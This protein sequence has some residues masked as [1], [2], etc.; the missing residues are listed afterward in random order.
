MDTVRKNDQFSTVL[1][2]NSNT[3]GLRQLQTPSVLRKQKKKKN[4][5]PLETGAKYFL[6]GM[7]ENAMRR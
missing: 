4:N 6:V 5:K 7:N 3:P 2:R 1:L